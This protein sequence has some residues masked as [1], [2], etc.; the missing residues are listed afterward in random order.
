[1]P[2]I[3]IVL[4][5]C[6]NG[7]KVSFHAS[8]ADA[9]LYRIVYTKIVSLDFMKVL[10]IRHAEAVEQTA[11]LPDGFRSLTSRGRKRFRLVAAALGHIGLA[12][13][14]IVASPRIR[15]VQT[16]EILAEAIRFNG[17]V[18]ISP[19]LG[20]D[21]DLAVLADILRTHASAKELVIVG[22]EP[23]LGEM[24]SGLLGMPA[25]PKLTKG[26]VVAMK[27]SPQNPESGAELTGLITGG[28][29]VIG[30]TGAARERLF[31]GTEE[32]RP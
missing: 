15:A 3:K 31:G 30:K 28:G 6:C 23:S 18:A 26:C 21:P 1:M 13:D 25:H 29:K 7:E 5:F 8:L 9:I 22:H 20:G 27:I 32:E 2:N 4:L 12:P 16:A 14:V 10:F 24:I 17:E 11:E 19:E